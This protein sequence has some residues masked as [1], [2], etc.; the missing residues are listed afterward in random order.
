MKAKNKLSS[1]RIS[2]D[3]LY[4]GKAQIIIHLADK[5]HQYHVVLADRSG[6]PDCKISSFSANLYARTNK[7]MAYEKYN[8]LSTLQTALVRL[9]DSK[10]ETKGDIRFTLSK[11]VMTI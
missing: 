10:V 7:G 8:S 1:L 11:E 4:E 2:L 6:K 3:E 9:V 5:H